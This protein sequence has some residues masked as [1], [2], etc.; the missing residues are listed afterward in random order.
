MWRI[1]SPCVCDMMDTY[2]VTLD[3]AFTSNMRGSWI[4]E[5]KK[6]QK[7]APALKTA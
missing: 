4:M 2:H 6:K 7:R 3:M 5:P 1:A